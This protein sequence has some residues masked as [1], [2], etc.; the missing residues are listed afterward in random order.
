MP[1][2]LPT[3]YSKIDL[4]K[5]AADMPKWH[6][7]LPPSAKEWWENFLKSFGH[8][9]CSDTPPDNTC[10]MYSLKNNVQRPNVQGLETTEIPAHISKIREKE[11]EP[12]EEVDIGLLKNCLSWYNGLY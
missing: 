3:D 6:S 9:T 2:L 10:P 4:A 1:T 7:V 11:L 8:T 12:L 5:L